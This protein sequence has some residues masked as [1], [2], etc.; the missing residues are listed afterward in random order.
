MHPIYTLGFN[1][2]LDKICPSV[3]AKAKHQCHKESIVYSS[4]ALSTCNE[5]NMH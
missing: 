3:A 1:A 2:W 4:D 5:S